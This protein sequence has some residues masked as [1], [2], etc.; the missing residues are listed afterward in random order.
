MLLLLGPSGRSPS[1]FVGDL[2]P[3][4]VP[5]LQTWRA[6]AVGP[7]YVVHAL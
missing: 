4:S 5:E 3:Y 7:E 2:V 6:G 1:P